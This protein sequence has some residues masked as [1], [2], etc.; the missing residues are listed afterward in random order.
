MLP[1]ALREAVEREAAVWDTAVLLAAAQAISRRYRA[2]NADGSPL[3]SGPAEAAA[4]AVSRMPATYEAVAAAI[5]QSGLIDLAPAALLDV[6]A[7]TGAAAWAAW[8]LL[9]L[10]KATCL[11]RENSMLELGRRLMAG[12]FSMEQTA[13]ARGDI[14][15]A[16]EPRP[17]DL[18]VA[19][20]VLNEMP[21]PTREQAL[22]RLWNAAGQALLLV[23]PGTTAG[24]QG[25]METRGFLLA[26][27]AHLLAPCPH[28]ETCPLPPGAWCRF[29]C[30]VP[31]SRLHKRLKGGDAPYEDERFFYLLLG[32]NARQA[33]PARLLRDPLVRGG[34]VELEL[35]ERAGITWRKW[36][37][38][39][40]ENYRLAQK[41]RSG[42]GIDFGQC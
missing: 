39:D 13:W 28:G 1:A 36:S 8:E 21:P 34:Y 16:G 12:V 30:R 3:A 29:T 6:G 33:P 35:C 42:E 2:E 11:E 24:Y 22:E 32:K 25:L 26:R 9:P 38:K 40:G 37:K 31:R 18:V 5:R 41:A 23:E 4:Y 14:L 17:A 10:R 15:A 19:A 27:G 7:G 20:Y